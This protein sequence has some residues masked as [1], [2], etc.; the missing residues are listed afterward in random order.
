V[1]R[2]LVGQRRGKGNEHDERMPCLFLECLWLSGL[3]QG[4]ATEI[5]TNVE[6]FLTLNAICLVQFCSPIVLLVPSLR[7]KD[8]RLCLM[9]CPV[10]LCS[11]PQAEMSPKHQVSARSIV[12][13]LGGTGGISYLA[14]SFPAIAVQVALVY[15]WHF[16]HIAKLRQPL[17]LRRD[18]YV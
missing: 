16:S 1:G 8:L 7:T 18:S 3:I 10:P 2:L 11:V 17:S 9:Q 14:S 4:C 5:C 15:I 6:K 12:V 13:N